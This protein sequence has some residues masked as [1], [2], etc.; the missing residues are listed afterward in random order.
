MFVRR[1]DPPRQEPAARYGLRE[2]LSIGVLALQGAEGVL[3][4]PD[5]VV[6]VLDSNGNP[7]EAVG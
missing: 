3:E 7:Y 4:V 2:T 6:H 1:R 5:E